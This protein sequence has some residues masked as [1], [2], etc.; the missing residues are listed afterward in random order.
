[1]TATPTS[2]GRPSSRIRVGV[3]AGTATEVQMWPTP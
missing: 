3:H 2:L 1:M